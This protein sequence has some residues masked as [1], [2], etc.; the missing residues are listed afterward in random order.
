M[1]GGWSCNSEQ[2]KSYG[3]PNNR[4]PKG[5]ISTARGATLVQNAEKVS[6][7]IKNEFNGNEI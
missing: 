4:D 6:Y 3:C 5:A 1:T 2:A 7:V